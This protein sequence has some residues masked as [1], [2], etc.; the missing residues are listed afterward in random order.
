MWNLILGFSLGVHNRTGAP[1]SLRSPFL[2]TMNCSRGTCELPKIALR[3][4]EPLSVRELAKLFDKHL[5]CAWCPIKYCHQ[6]T[7]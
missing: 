4:R 2:Y 1:P 3:G 5:S 6:Q 7:A